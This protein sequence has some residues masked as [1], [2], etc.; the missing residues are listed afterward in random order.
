MGTMTR[1][2]QAEASNQEHTWIFYLGGRVPHTVPPSLLFLGQWQEDGLQVK[3]PECMNRHPNGML[4]SQAVS[5]TI[6]PQCWHPH[7]WHNFV[8]IVPPL[9]LELAD[10]F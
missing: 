4:A 8:H 1:V 6:E 7:L 2:G 3:Q 5:F 10:G 9:Q